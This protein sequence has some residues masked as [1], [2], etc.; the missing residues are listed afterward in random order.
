MASLLCARAIDTIGESGKH[1]LYS[2][3]KLLEARR[4]YERRNDIPLSYA[5]Q[6]KLTEFYG[7]PA[8]ESDTSPIPEPDVEP[9]VE[10]E[11]APDEPPTE[12]VRSVVKESDHFKIC[13]D[14]GLQM[15]QSIK[16]KNAWFCWGCNVTMVKAKDKWMPV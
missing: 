16:H 15:G 9:L 10:K 3:E 11:E 13:P 14:C 5:S 8:G 6:I 7:E 2:A 12:P 1:V 4:E